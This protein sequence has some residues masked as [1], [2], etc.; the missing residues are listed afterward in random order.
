MRSQ[1]CIRKEIN[2]ARGYYQDPNGKWHK[3]NGD[4]ASN[5]EVGLPN[6][7]PVSKNRTRG[8]RLGNESTRAQ[9]REIAEYLKEHG[10]TIIG[11][12]GMHQEEYLPGP[13]SGHRGSN[14]VD[15]TAIKGSETIRI[16]TVDVCADGTP[17]V[18]ENNAAISINQKTGGNI[19][20]IPKGKGIGNLAQILGLN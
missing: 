17:T 15:V 2:E 11:G 4:F 18:R 8:G 6:G 5:K 19:I 9:N 20:L 12:G 3:P 14:Y 7:R 16:N 1:E 13:N 10:Y